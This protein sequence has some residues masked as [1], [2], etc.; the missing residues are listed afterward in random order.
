MRL[1]ASNPV[2]VIVIGVP[3]REQ[4]EPGTGADLYQRQWFRQQG[5]DG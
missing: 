4:G 1:G 3:V 2:P 5:Q